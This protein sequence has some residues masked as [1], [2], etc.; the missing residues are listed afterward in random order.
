MNMLLP[1]G[2]AITEDGLKCFWGTECS[3]VKF[4]FP[5]VT[6]LCLI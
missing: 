5:R 3:P 4:W 2:K 6:C 1:D